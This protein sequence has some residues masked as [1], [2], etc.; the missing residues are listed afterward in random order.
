MGISPEVQAALD[1]I[2][3]SRLLTEKA[4][5][6]VEKAKQESLASQA[7]EEGRI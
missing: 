7:V 2:V 1:A 3:Q 5:Q 6:D 4:K